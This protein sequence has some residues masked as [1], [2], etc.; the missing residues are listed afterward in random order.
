MESRLKSALALLLGEMG[1]DTVIE[2]EVLLITTTKVAKSK[3][4]TRVYDL[5]GLGDIQ[6]EALVS[7]ISKVHHPRD[8]E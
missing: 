3:M 5:R 7:T 8:L 2:N 1:L 6:P 4:E